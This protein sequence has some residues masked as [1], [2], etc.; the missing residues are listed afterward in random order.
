MWFG[1]SARCR[2]RTTRGALVGRAALRAGTTAADVERAIA[3]RRIVRT[4]PMRG[5]LHFVAPADVRWMLALLSPR[6]SRGRRH[7]T[8]RSAHAETI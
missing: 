6:V 2:R 8:R 4:W 1:I 7:G 5:T 3:E